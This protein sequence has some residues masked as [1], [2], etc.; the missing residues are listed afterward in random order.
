MEGEFYRDNLEQI[1]KFTEGKH[2]L[3]ISETMRFTGV[4]DSRTARR[5]FPF[6]ANGYISAATLAR[7]MTKTK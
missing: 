3:N 2:L 6:N 5:L 1:L 7:S 4:A